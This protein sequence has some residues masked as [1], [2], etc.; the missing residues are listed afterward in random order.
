[1]TIIKTLSIIDRL[2]TNACKAGLIIN[3]YNKYSPIYSMLFS[4][5]LNALH[6]T[7]YLHKNYRFKVYTL[8]KMGICC[9]TRECEHKHYEIMG[10]YRMITV[11]L[12]S[13][14]KCSRRTF[15][16]PRRNFLGEDEQ[17]NMKNFH[18]NAL[19]TKK[20]LR[21]MFN[22]VYFRFISNNE[23]REHYFNRWLEGLRR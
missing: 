13:V 14:F 11:C 19:I 6:S 10:L 16:T 20:S 5:A 4:I 12:E 18:E 23:S 21:L 8:M 22:E 3:C 15:I 2:Y 17:R 1:M 7:Q 9:R